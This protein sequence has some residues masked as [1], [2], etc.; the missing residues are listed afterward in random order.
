MSN[1]SNEP[2]D[3]NLGL[4][5]SI[6]LITSLIIGISF[7]LLLHKFS[8]RII[9]IVSNYSVIIGLINGLLGGIVLGIYV[10][11]LKD[12]DLIAAL[13]SVLVFVAFTIYI[14][15]LI[16]VQ[17]YLNT[18]VKW[19][20][21]TVKKKRIDS[22]PKLKQFIKETDQTILMEGVNCS[23][24][25]HTRNDTNSVLLDLRSFNKVTIDKKNETATVRGQSTWLDVLKESS[26]HDLTPLVLQSAPWFTVAGSVSSN[27]HGRSTSI[28]KLMDVILEIKFVD[29]NGVNHVVDR[30]H[31][32]FKYLNGSY[33][34]LGVIY[35]IKFKIFP[36]KSVH[37]EYK[38]FSSLQNVKDVIFDPKTKFF[39]M[40]SVFYGTTKQIK[41]RYVCKI[42]TEIEN[43]NEKFD[44]QRYTDTTIAFK[45]YLLMNLLHKLGYLPFTDDLRWKAEISF[46][47]TMKP[48]DTIISN[49]FSK[50]TYPNGIKNFEIQ[51]FFIPIKHFV[52]FRNEFFKIFPYNLVFTGS[53]YVYT[54][55]P[56][57][58]DY[59]KKGIKILSFVVNYIANH[60]EYWKSIVQ[61]LYKLMIKYDTTF[62]LC[63]N[64]Q[65]GLTGTQ[66]RKIFPK[67][68]D[69]LQMKKELDP[70]N[71]FR[72]RFYDYLIK[73]S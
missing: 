68:K 9:S 7:T 37:I 18:D 53:R 3:Q 4:G 46:N 50:F 52:K 17:Q 54:E 69:F 2:D 65:D 28:T 39:H 67:I 63:Y 27:I 72:T 60:D 36:I 70:K 71:K 45:D 29:G 59:A 43:V 12:A 42:Y 64:L 21:T 10:G 19:Y 5:I 40:N 30:K 6:G 31:K 1:N 33:G 11:K 62:H 49:S 13:V 56:C 34:L 20:Y 14:L 38:Y 23:S 15:F 32:L 22:I 41:D 16:P 58:L 48:K 57:I 24:N 8:P 73:D 26:K 51:E 25:I 66:I 35:E 44:L 55:D 47:Y 61:K